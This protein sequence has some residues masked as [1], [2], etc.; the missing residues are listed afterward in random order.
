MSIN[1]WAKRRDGNEHA[2]IRTVEALGGFY[3][4]TGPLDGW[5]HSRHA[6]ASCGAPGWRLLEVKEPKREGHANEFTPEQ[7]KL[8]LRLNERQIPYHTIRTDADVYDLL[9]VRRTA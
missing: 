8:I 6:C 4:Q 1:R 3:L 7:R 9:N 5:L 2:L